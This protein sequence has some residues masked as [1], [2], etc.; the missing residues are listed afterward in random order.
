MAY[1]KE[2]VLNTRVYFFNTQPIVMDQIP[3]TQL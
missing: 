1:P 3:F 2:T